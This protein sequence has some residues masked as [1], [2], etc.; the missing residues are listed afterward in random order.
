VQVE[1][2]LQQG[3]QLVVAQRPV[4]AYPPNARAELFDGGDAACAV[5]RLAQ[6]APSARRET[7]ARR[8]P[9]ARPALPAR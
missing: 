4:Q 6:Q 1:R 5:A 2:R 3:R 8:A 9:L 7:R